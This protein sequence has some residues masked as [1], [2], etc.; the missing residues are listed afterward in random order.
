MPVRRGVD[1]FHESAVDK[2]AEDEAVVEVD[3]QQTESNASDHP[4]L[5]VD[6]DTQPTGVLP[7][8]LT[9]I[10]IGVK[11]SVDRNEWKLMGVK[12]LARACMHHGKLHLVLHDGALLCTSCSECS[13][14]T[15]VVQ[16]KV[17]VYLGR[18]LLECIHQ[19]VLMFSLHLGAGCDGKTLLMTVHLSKSC[20]S[21]P[22]PVLR[23]IL[24]EPSS[25]T[26]G[27]VAVDDNFSA[28]GFLTEIA[29]SFRGSVNND[30][31]RC[32]LGDAGIRTEMRNYQLQGVQWMHDRL[33]GAP[34]L[35]GD[36][37]QY[38]QGWIRLP[39][40]TTTNTGTSSST[41][42]GSSAAASSCWYNIHTE[43]VYFGATPVSADLQDA[44]ESQRGLIL[45][46]EMG[47]GKSLQI[48]A[49]VSLLK[50]NAVHDATRVGGS[51]AADDAAAG[52]GRDVL[53]GPQRTCLCGS[54][55]DL[56]LRSHGEYA[57]LGWVQCSSCDTW[58][59]AP[60]AGFQSAEALEACD[61]YTCLA[62]SCLQTYHRPIPTRTTL[63][64]M[65]NTLIAQWRAELLKH[66]AT[67]TFNNPHAPAGL[68]V[69][70]YPENIAVG[71]GFSGGKGAITDYGRLDPRTLAHYD[72]ILLSFRALQKGYHEANVD[73]SS[74]RIRRSI[75]AIF[76]PPFLCL[77]YHLLVVDETQNIEAPSGSS[78]TL[79]MACR[80][81]SQHRISVSGTPLG[82]GRLSDL[83]SLSMFLR[84][85]PLCQRSIWSR[86]IERPVVPVPALWRVHV[87]QSLFGAI[88]IRRTKDMIREQLALPRHSVVTHILQFSTFE[89]SMF[90]ILYRT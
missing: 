29:A 4:L 51:M 77:R 66:T 20:T 14:D 65:P 36:V 9:D 86:L 5:I 68:K 11:D 63:I 13:D 61:V 15:L 53:D 18:L 7:R 46:D 40:V 87:L 81:P 22:P 70:I 39:K 62:C 54:A 24:L 27:D 45:A 49:L 52:K 3:E 44:D 69:F 82:T 59:H 41:S 32:T 6:R 8:N 19:K 58:L 33:S 50:A 67:V 2:F 72:I 47:V 30:E 73:Y 1:R 34:V 85:E 83:H 25:Y 31:L 16:E 28:S 71:E 12:T 56:P 35:D 17:G 21:L 10:V 74:E 60:C 48:I 23:W 57:L 89:V 79:N 55:D 37:A 42:H 64:V 84:I 75:Y 80:I 88:T 90:C 38:L 26:T 76:P 78:Q 43:A